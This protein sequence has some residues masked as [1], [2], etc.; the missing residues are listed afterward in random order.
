MGKSRTPMTPS[1][2]DTSNL[3]TRSPTIT[4]TRT[5]AIDAQSH[6]RAASSS[7]L[8]AASLVSL[9][10]DVSTQTRIAPNLGVAPVIVS[11]LQ[12]PDTAAG[13]IDPTKNRI[14][15]A[16]R[17]SS[18]AGA[19]RRI[20]T[21]TLDG[22]QAN[23]GDGLIDNGEAEDEAGGGGTRVVPIGGAWQAQAEELA[24][25]ARNP[26]SLVLDHEN[27]VVGT[28]EGLVYRMG[29]VGSAY[30][31]GW[32]DAK[33]EEEDHLETNGE[34]PAHAPKGDADTI[35]NLLHLRDVWR[36]LFV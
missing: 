34:D 2:S 6:P 32:I 33:R 12:T 36:E 14:I 5:A 17:F 9:G 26:M 18:R 11:V 27:C 4:R 35:T 22:R 8:P 16:S 23:G 13:C 21:S 24:V 3:A 29:F 20:Y 15:L 19:D 1:T 7:P 10:D 30:T 31:D 25:P 28:S